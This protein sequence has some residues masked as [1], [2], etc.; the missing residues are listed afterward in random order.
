M[1]SPVSKARR[2]KAPAYK[3]KVAL[4]AAREESTVAEISR[5]DGVH[6]NQVRVEGEAARRR[7]GRFRVTVRGPTRVQLEIRAGHFSYQR[8]AESISREAATD[9]V[10]VIRSNASAAGHS[11]ADLVRR[12]KA[13]VPHFGESV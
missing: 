7:G 3:A 9:G 10:Y 1:E 2:N 13:H 4:E 12:Y 6:V 8:T 11:A 5:N